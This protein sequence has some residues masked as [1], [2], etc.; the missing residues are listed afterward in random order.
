MSGTLE[1]YTDAHPVTALLIIEVTDTTLAYDRHNTAGP[2][3]TKS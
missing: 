2:N 3:Q 1:D